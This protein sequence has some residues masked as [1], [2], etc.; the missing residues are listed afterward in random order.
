M[1]KTILITSSTSL[2]FCYVLVNKDE[3]NN[4]D[5]NDKVKSLSTFFISKKL[6]EV[7]YFT[8]N[9]KKIF[10]LLWNTFI[11]VLIFYFFD[12]KYYICIKT[13]IFS[14][15]MNEVLNWLI[16]NYLDQ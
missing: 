12:L 8:F 16:L 5:N 7:D 3:V 2:K 9:I 1:L 13:N 10:N 15:I 6:T 4:G 11:R 14:N